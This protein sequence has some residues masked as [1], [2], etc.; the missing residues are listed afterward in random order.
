MEK[1]NQKWTGNHLSVMRKPVVKDNG[2]RKDCTTLTAQ[3]K[4]NVETVTQ[5]VR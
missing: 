2:C 1:S 4:R 3:M 5:E